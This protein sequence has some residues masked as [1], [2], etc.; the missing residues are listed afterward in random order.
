MLNFAAS[1]AR[2]ISPFCCSDTRMLT[3]L[4]SPP[5]YAFLQRVNINN[6]KA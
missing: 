5:V 2:S 3:T 4:I 6:G 1:A